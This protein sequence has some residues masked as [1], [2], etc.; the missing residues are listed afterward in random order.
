MWA[1]T[2]GLDFNGREEW[3]GH[4]KHTGLSREQA[5]EAFCQLYADAMADQAGNFRK[6]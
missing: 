5:K 4:M 2:G 1:A 3:E 6:M